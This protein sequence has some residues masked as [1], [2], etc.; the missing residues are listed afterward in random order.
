MLSDWNDPED[1][2]N[3]VAQGDEVC[4]VR[5]KGLQRDVS[6]YTC[7]QILSVSIFEKTRFHAPCSNLSHSPT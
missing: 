1:S 5:K 2:I 3:A 4:A 7:V 6:L